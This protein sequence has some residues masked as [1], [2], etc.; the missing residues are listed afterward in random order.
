M[1]VLNYNSAADSDTSSIV[2]MSSLGN[3]FHKL[4]NIIG[5]SVAVESTGRKVCV[6]VDPGASCDLKPFLKSQRN[7]RTN[8]S[9]SHLHTDLCRAARQST[10]LNRNTLA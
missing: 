5:V 1:L 9:L 6:E 4:E 2:F 7:Y 8:F 3:F 10:G